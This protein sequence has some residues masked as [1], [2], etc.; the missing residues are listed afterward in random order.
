MKF[1]SNCGKEVK[2]NEINCPFCGKPLV[3][4]AYN[5]EDEKKANMLCS[6]SA[7]CTYGSTLLAAFLFFFAHYTLKDILLWFGAFPVIGLALMTN[8]L[9]SHPN[10][11]FVKAL[12]YADIIFFLFLVVL[13]IASIVI[14][15]YSCSQIKG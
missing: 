6:I 8:V 1:C 14:F 10:N 12:M 7:I 15:A 4:N 5:Y 2:G 3:S 11:R 13:I 9:D